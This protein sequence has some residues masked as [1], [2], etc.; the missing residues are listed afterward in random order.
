MHSF[1]LLFLSRGLIKSLQAPSGL[2]HLAITL[3]ASVHHRLLEHGFFCRETTMTELVT[4]LWFDEGRAREAAQFYAATF[5][6]RH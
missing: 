4:C 6:D 3:R 5:P 1:F 2:V